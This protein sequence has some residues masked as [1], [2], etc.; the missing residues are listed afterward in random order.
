MS[1]WLQPMDTSQR[2]KTYCTIFK[3][4]KMKIFATGNVIHLDKTSKINHVTLARVVGLINLGSNNGEN[5]FG[6]CGLKAVI[7]FNDLIYILDF[8]EEVKI[9]TN[10]NIIVTEC[11]CPLFRTGLDST[12]QF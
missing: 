6:W 8:P 9:T 11:K 4:L 12:F 10:D 5:D 3:K 7:N 1:P 2:L